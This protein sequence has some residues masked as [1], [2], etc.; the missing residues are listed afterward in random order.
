MQMSLCARPGQLFPGIL[1]HITAFLN[2]VVS[3]AC[4]TN[5]LS[6]N[7][8][9][10]YDML[11]QEEVCKVGLLEGKKKK[12]TKRKRKEHS[13][14]SICQEDSTRACSTGGACAILRVLLVD[15]DCSSHHLY[16]EEE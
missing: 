4:S 12:E 13:F 7:L 10:F 9:Q 14:C 6:F 2:V 1:Q 15:D 8:P 3:T 5:H 16:H 11:P